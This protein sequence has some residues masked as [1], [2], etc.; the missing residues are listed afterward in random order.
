MYEHILVATDGSEISGRAVSY[1][2]DLARKLSAKFLIVTITEPFHVVSLEIEQLES[3]RLEYTRH[4]AERA[5]TVLASAAKIASDAGVESEVLH[6]SAEH[7][8][9]AIL[10]VANDHGCDL[11]VVGSHGRS[12]LSALFL[13]STTIKILAHSTIPVL[14]V[15]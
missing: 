14:V 9:A 4:M 8:Y 2:A 10:D 3:T 5:Q 6:R 1:A 11:I 7:P 15:R 12:G 13:G